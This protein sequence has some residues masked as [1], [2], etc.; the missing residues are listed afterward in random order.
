MSLQCA[1]M[2]GK[3]S[4][5]LIEEFYQLIGRY[6]RKATSVARNAN[7]LGQERLRRF[8]KSGEGNHDW[9]EMLRHEK[10]SKKG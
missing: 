9:I 1:K 8:Q 10:S 7:N 2:N 5:Q 4:L 3:L 6:P